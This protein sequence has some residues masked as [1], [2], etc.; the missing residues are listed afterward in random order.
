[1]PENMLK[2]VFVSL[3]FKTLLMKFDN[4]DPLRLP[5]RK[6]NLQLP[7]QWNLFREFNKRS[8]FIPF[9]MFSLRSVLS[10]LDTS[11]LFGTYPNLFELFINHRFNTMKLLILFK[12]L[13]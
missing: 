11:F 8:E 6:L 4:I 12:S 7:I 5:Q 3:L 13:N 1:M 2:H 10:W 9:H